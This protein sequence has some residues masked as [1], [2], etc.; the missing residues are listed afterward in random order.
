MAPV[1]MGAGHWEDHHQFQF[2]SNLALS[3]KKTFAHGHLPYGLGAKDVEPHFCLS[4][5]DNHPTNGTAKAFSERYGIVG[6]PRVCCSYS[7]S[8]MGNN[9]NVS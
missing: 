1:A 8:Q 7:Y 6:P 9:Y 4:M 3:W 5:E 2:P